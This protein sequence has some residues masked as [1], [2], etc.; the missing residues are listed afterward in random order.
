MLQ[1]PDPELERI[2]Q[3]I[4]L[5]GSQPPDT[6]RTGR[7]LDAIRGNLRRLAAERRTLLERVG[8]LGARAENEPAGDA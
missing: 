6:G 8:A 1:P 5:L 4:A 3:Q 2:K 7:E